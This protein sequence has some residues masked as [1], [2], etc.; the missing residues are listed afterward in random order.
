MEQPNIFT[1][2]KDTSLLK[3]FSEIHNSIYANDGLS[4]QQALD[5]MLKVLFMKVFN[6]KLRKNWFWIDEKE[7]KECLDNN[8]SNDFTERTFELWE[9]SKKDFTDIF[10]PNEK[11]KL[12]L[13]SLAFA[14]NKLQHIDFSDTTDAKGLAFQKF[15]AST[16]KADRG[17][18]FTPEPVIN[19]CVEFL[20]PK[21]HEK[22]IDPTCGSGGF[23][24][25]AYQYLSDNFQTSKQE[26][27]PNLFGIDINKTIVKIAKMKL[28]LECNTNLNIVAQNSLED[29]DELA[30]S[31]GQQIENQ[32]DIVLANPPFGT[33]GKITNEKLLRKYELGYKWQG[34]NTNYFKTKTLHTGQTPEILFIERCLQLLKEGGRMAIVLPNGMFENP[35]LEYLRY[36]IKQKTKVLAVVNLP[37]ETFIPFGTGVKTSILFLEKQTSQVLKTCEVSEPKVFFGRVTK[38]GYQGNKNGNPIYQKDEFGNLL[39]N[40]NKEPILEEDFSK[41][42]QDYKQFQITNEIAIETENSFTFPVAELTGRFDFDYYAPQNRKLLNKLTSQNA[43]KLADLCEIVKIKS[44]KLSQANETVD[45]IE[46][47]D[48]NTH[49]YEI[50]NATSYLVHELPSRASYEVRENDILTAVAGNSIGTN[51]HATALATKDYEGSI[52]T[53]GFRILRNCKVDLYYLL[54]YLRTEMFLKQVFMYRTG[55]AIPNISDYDLGRIL[56]Y[57]PEGKVLQE[58]SEKVRYSFELRKQAKEEVEKIRIEF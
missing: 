22:I 32:M 45:Y 52:C 10:E 40:K 23:L 25:S 6:R 13:A 34:E 46:L 41:I 47:S 36:F 12:S 48:I 28:L 37:Q 16:E 57:L 44:K 39:K 55:A 3:K 30:L 43:V 38:L 14:V 11:I 9:K 53:N 49:S 31:F 20:Q 15:L 21:P 56:V 50:I 19:F 42:I 33:L 5:E 29:L 1:L 2:Q 4:A 7:Y 51:K 18:F 54:Y 27:I 35:S 58:I 17:Q 26:I 8:V 24:F